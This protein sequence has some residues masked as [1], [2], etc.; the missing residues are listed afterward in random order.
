M[1]VVPGVICGSTPAFRCPREGAGMSVTAAK[2]P[3]DLICENVVSAKYEDLSEWNIKCTKDRLI[4]ITGCI[5]GGAT[6]QGNAG[7]VK[8]VRDYGGKEEA[9]IFIHGGRA[10]AGNAAM[11][12]CISAR[13]ND[14]GVMY[15]NIDGMRIPSHN[16]ETTIPMALT[17]SDA[18][19]VSGKEF[20]VS[21]LVGDD[22]S[23]RVLAAGGWDFSKGWDGT[24]TIPTWGAV[25]I[26]GRFLGL[27]P[28]QL[29][30]AFGIGVNTI[31]GALQ[32]LD[33]YSL[34]FKLGQGTCARNGM[35][36]AELAR[37]GWNGLVDPLGGGKAYFYLYTGKNEIPHPELLTKDLGKKFYMEESFKRYPCGI[38]NTPYVLAG[39]RIHNRLGNFKVSD[40]R[41]IELANSSKQRTNY[42]SQQFRIGAAP[43]VNGIFSFQYIAICAIL[44]GEVKIQYF[45][46]EAVTDPGIVELCKKSRVVVDESIKS[47]F[48]SA[49]DAGNADPM[50]NGVRLRVV[51]T[52]GR[53]LEE[54]EPNRTM[55]NYPTKEELESKFW[56]QVNAFNNVSES[57]GKKLLD[58]IEKI[59]D[60]EN[61]K[62][63]TELLMPRKCH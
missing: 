2:L 22:A 30:D 38:P 41:E 9:P 24:M 45:T 32:S 39:K 52:D 53:V 3:I 56:D 50:V 23:N 42:Y 26:A 35:F 12:N 16:S 47:R 20:L 36:A 7:L 57:T 43:Q 6:A 40:I 58:M 27:T 34:T 62:E 51:A 48:A 11:V 55:H 14:F 4:D 44:R 15:A 63:F 61:M 37:E 21:T 31:A 18:Y 46:P 25:S 60:V 5:I 10:P 33:D 59:E 17:L 49:S 13:S 54:Y 1:Q 29:K 28:Q 19:G 8:I